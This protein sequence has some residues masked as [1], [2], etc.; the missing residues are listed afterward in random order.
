MARWLKVNS[1]LIKI[2]LKICCKYLKLLKSYNIDFVVI[3]KSD[4]IGGLW[5][6]R[7]DDYG[8]MEFTHINV[9]KYNYCFTDHQFPNDAADYPHHSEMFKYIKS[10]AEKNELIGNNTKI[11]FNTQ[12]VL[13]EGYFLFE[14][15]LHY[16]TKIKHAFLIQ[17]LEADHELIKNKPIFDN[18]KFF[19]KL[20][21]IIVKDLKTNKESIYITP[22]VSIASG[23]HGTPTYA[24][25][26][27]QDSFK[28]N[29]PFNL[30][31]DCLFN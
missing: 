2:E 23:H 28:G 5:R 17:E 25:F 6:Y 11:S 16:L 20:W 12:V 27:G 10:Y 4:D 8:V 7:K 31:K 26:P 22:Y 18:V 9:S 21:K 3:E 13:V 24:Q 1:A 15:H 14:F 29:V 19:D 30:M